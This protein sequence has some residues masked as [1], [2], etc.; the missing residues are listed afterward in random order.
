MSKIFTSLSQKKFNKICFTSTNMSITCDSGAVLTTSANVIISK[1][2]SNTILFDENQNSKFEIL[3][4]IFDL[5]IDYC[6]FDEK[7]G[8]ISIFFVEKNIYLKI[9]HGKGQPDICFLV[10]GDIYE[11]I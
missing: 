7:F 8:V 1:N 9:T 11:P 4:E 6:F 10:D 3:N 5:V 2:E